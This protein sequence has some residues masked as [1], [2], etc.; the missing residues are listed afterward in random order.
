MVCCLLLGGLMLLGPRGVQLWQVFA[1]PRGERLQV[2]GPVEIRTGRHLVG[3]ASLSDMAV[4][5]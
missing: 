4:V 3:T 2:R 1:R 5:G